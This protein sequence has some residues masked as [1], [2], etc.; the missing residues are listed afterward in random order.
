MPQLVVKHRRLH[1]AGDRL[2]REN[3]I[4]PVILKLVDQ[5]RKFPLPDNQMGGPGVMECG[6]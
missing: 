6:F 3:Q 2:I 4:E 1:G 5:H